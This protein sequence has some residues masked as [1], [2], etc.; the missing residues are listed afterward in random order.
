MLGILRLK[1]HLKRFK[2]QPVVIFQWI[3]GEFDG[4]FT[5][6]IEAFF[7]ILPNYIDMDIKFI[8]LTL[9]RQVATKSHVRLHFP[10]ML[11]IMCSTKCVS[12]NSYL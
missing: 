5:Q 12:L 11:P 6:L 4:I 9:F 8:I 3:L 1:A 10:N 2:S 7:K